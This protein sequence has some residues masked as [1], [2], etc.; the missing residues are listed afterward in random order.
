MYDNDPEYNDYDDDE[1]KQ[2]PEYNDYGYPKQ[3]S[4]DWSAWELWLADAIKEI[5]EENNTWIVGSY[6]KEEPNKDKSKKKQQKTSNSKWSD[7][8]FMYLGNNAF[9]EPIWKMKYFLIDEISQAYKKHIVANA[10][11]FLQQPEYYKG[12]FDILN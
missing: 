12:M 5:Y 1:Y 2:Y 6:N 8:Y 11:H 7:D 10:K 4:F 3:F 9:Q